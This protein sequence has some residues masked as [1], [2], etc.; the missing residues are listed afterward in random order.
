MSNYSTN[1]PINNQTFESAHA[2]VDFNIQDLGRS[3]INEG[4]DISRAEREFYEFSQQLHRRSIIQSW[5]NASEETIAGF[6]AANI[7][8]ASLSTHNDVEKAGK[9]D[10]QEG[11]FDL[12]EYLTSS[13]DSYH[14]AGI[15]HKVCVSGIAHATNRLIYSS[16]ARW[17]HLGKS[18]G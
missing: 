10:H 6:S 11:E 1:P 2:Y 4:V 8:G 7:G 17:C 15:K 14:Q 3:S 16:P 13:N 12:R 9:I 18:A 5:S